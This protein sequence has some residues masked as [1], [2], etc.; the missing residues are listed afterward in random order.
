[1]PSALPPTFTGRFEQDVAPGG[2]DFADVMRCVPLDFTLFEIAV[3][4]LAYWKLVVG[5]FRYGDSNDL[6]IRIRIFISIT[7]Y[8]SLE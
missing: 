2:H 3:P 1:M 6:K 7:L 5:E 4:S 8:I